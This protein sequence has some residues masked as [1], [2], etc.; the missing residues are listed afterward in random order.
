MSCYG[1]HSSAEA[2]AGGVREESGEGDRDLIRACET[3]QAI[4]RR[5][6]GSHSGGH[7]EGVRCAFEIVH[8]DSCVGDRAGRHC[9]AA[10][11]SMILASL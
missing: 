6:M 5:R 3:C 2:E 7:V 9:L 1:S 10:A 8:P 4:W 11:H